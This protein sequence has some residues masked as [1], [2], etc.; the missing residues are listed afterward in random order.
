MLGKYLEFFESLHVSKHQNNNSNFCVETNCLPHNSSVMPTYEDAD[1]EIEDTY[2]GLDGIMRS[3]P[4]KIL[5]LEILFAIN[6]IITTTDTS[7]TL[8]TIHGA[9]AVNMKMFC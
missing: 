4:K 9:A 6:N 2:S 8:N 7:L 3:A 1:S 5:I